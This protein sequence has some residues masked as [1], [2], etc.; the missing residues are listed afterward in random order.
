MT[1]QTLP[2]GTDGIT[3]THELQ[4]GMFIAIPAWKTFGCIL[5]T[6]AP[7]MG[8]DD[9]IIVH[10]QEDPESDATRLYT[11]DAVEYPGCYTIED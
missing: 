9:A 3:D 2:T 7:M 5:K 10:L 8:S 1:T 6:E 11:L 4:P